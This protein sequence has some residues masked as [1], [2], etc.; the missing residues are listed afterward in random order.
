[1]ICVGRCK[2]TSLPNVEGDPWK[3][4][5]FFCDIKNSLLEDHEGSDALQVTLATAKPKLTELK[6]LIHINGLTEDVC[7]FREGQKNV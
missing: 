7:P 3:N 1:M 6:L 2:S 5:K 4:I